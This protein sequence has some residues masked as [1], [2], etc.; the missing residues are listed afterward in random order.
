M[1]RR[2][3]VFAVLLTLAGLLATACTDTGS[4]PT[5]PTPTI[6]ADTWTRIFPDVPT[7]PLYA[8]WGMDIDDMWI[9]GGAGTILHWDGRHAEWVDSPTRRRLHDIDGCAR[10]DIWAISDDL[11]VIHWDGRRWSQDRLE[12]ADELYDVHCAG[13][14]EVYIGGWDHEHQRLILRFDGTNWRK[15]PIAHEQAGPVYQIW[16][17]GPDRPLMAA[18]E[19]S[20]LWY[21]AGVWRTV[22]QFAGVGDADGDLVLARLDPGSSWRSL[23]RVDTGGRLVEI[24]SSSY[25]AHGSDVADVEPIVVAIDNDLTRLD[26]CITRQFYDGRWWIEW[27]S[28][29]AVPVHRG[30]SILAVGEGPVAKLVTWNGLEMVAEDLMT[31]PHDL[32]S[33][34][35]TGDEDDLYAVSINHCLLVFDGD[36]PSPVITPLDGNLSQVRCL[37]G[38]QLVVWGDDQIA[39]RDPSGIWATLPPAPVSLNRFWIDGSLQPRVLDSNELWGL[40]SGAWSIIDTIPHAD[41]YWHVDSFAGLAPD[42]LYA[43]IREDGHSR[44]V[45]HDGAGWH[46]S[47]LAPD[48]E[49]HHVVAGPLTHS[50]YFNARDSQGELVN[51]RIRDETV[52]IFATEYFYLH[53]IVE[54]TESL[55]FARN[56]DD[57]YQ[58]D[59]D[60]WR[61]IATPGHDHYRSVWGHPD[62]GLYLLSSTYEIHHRPLPR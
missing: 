7:Q 41:G 58:L 19:D 36:Q 34:S 22:D 29:L 45:E 52:T 31:F 9:V 32:P 17:P 54:V 27:F 20:I 28:D 49:I 14:D 16:R 48:L 3:V 38:D 40:E 13:P 53:D 6:S 26:S 8:A 62:H 5:E 4:L 42:E 21:D 18:V 25:V 59:S 10:D 61:P 30:P 24:C 15:M 57:L 44:L 11:Q 1:S 23:C 50:L 55:V 39:V 37:D 51:G 33:R 60:S 43:T 2:H 12:Q 46:D 35:L 47:D 56:D